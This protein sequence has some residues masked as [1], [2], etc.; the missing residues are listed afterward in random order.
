MKV[1]RR[2]RKSRK[3]ML[4]VTSQLRVETLLFLSRENIQNTER[5]KKNQLFRGDDEDF[6]LRQEELLGRKKISP[7]IE[8]NIQIFH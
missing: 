3:H 5:K 2:I 8:C 1:W 4:K 7:L 6:M